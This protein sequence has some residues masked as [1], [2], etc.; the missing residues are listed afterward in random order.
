[1]SGIFEL[2]DVTFTHNPNIPPVM[3]G[4]N[5]SIKEGSHTAILG[6][7]GAGKT[8]LFYTLT[9]VYKPQK[10]QVL[11]KGEPLEYT[12]KGLQ[13][14]RS[15]AAVVL[16][17]PDEQ[18]FCSLV[19]EDVAFGPLN[20]DVPLDEVEERVDAALKA[21]RM[22]QYRKRPSQQLSGGQ[23]KRVAIAGALAMRPKVM[24][25]DEPTAGLDPQA[26][27]EVIELA[28]KLSLSGVTVM[29]ST[30]D[31][32]I[33]YRWADVSS[34]LKKGKIEFSGDTDEFY[35]DAEMTYRC[36]LLTPSIFAMN[37]DVSAIRGKDPS[38]YPHNVCEF[39]AKYSEGPKS[40]RILL[41]PCDAECAPQKYEA[42][43]ADMKDA[44]TAVYGS[45][46][47]YSLTNMEIDIAFDGLDSCMTEAI[48]GNDSI[49]FYDRIYKPIVEKQISRLK[50]F[51]FDAD[52]EV[53]E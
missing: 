26:S 31:I 43:T 22:T 36:G 10:G 9:G 21:V 19:E 7:N 25:M 44:Y 49:L 50:W 47:R 18:I 42:A 39:S 38:P 17:N 1:M 13:R 35:S 34:V 52:T 40:G 41:V 5:L 3:D 15:E 45:D 8:T 29:I 27:M 6:A 2:E 48:R 53:F 24:I 30:H 16:Q 12:P 37:R 28:E 23:R 14:I 4:F 51:G 11:Y 33:A 20:L 32:D 46:A